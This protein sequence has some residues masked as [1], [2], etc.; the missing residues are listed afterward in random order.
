MYLERLSKEFPN[1]SQ[2]E[3]EAERDARLNNVITTKV[4]YPDEPLANLWIYIR[5]I[6][7][8]KFHQKVSLYYERTGSG[9]GRGLIELEPEYRPEGMPR[10]AGAYQYP[11][12][13]F[14]L[15]PLHERF[16]RWWT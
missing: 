16:C 8:K 1:Y 10:I 11:Y 12:P 9:S 6:L 3:L 15:V 7:W 4:T 2:S 14:E 13:G 5:T